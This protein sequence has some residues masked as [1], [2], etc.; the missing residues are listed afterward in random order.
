M[1]EPTPSWRRRLRST[2]DSTVRVWRHR[3]FRGARIS[4]AVGLV[5]ITAAMIGVMLFAHTGINVG[6]FRAE[7]SLS[8]S[9]A[10]GTEVDIPPLGSLHLDSHR[11]ALHLKVALGS[12][13]Q[14]RTEALIDNPAAISSAGDRAVEEVTTGV[15]RLALRAIGL[16]VLGAIL[17]A[18]LIF[19]SVRRTAAAGVTALVVGAGSFGVAA[20]TL[21]PDA[22]SEPRYEGLLVNAPAVV[23]D[24]RRIADNY[25]RY[26]EQ[27]QQIVSNVSRIYTT[28]SALP[29]YEPAGN[30]TRILHV[31]DLHLNPSS[32]GL[33]R[34]VVQTFDIDAVIDTGDM[35]DWGSSA[36]TSYVSS[37]PSLNVPYLYVR[38]NHDSVAI[39]S[40]V[41]RQRNAVVLDDKLTTVDG[42]TVAGI[43][44]PQFTPDKSETNKAGDTSGSEILTAAGDRLAKTIRDSGKKVDIALIH[45]PEMAPPLAGVVPLVLAGHRHQ[46]S[47]AMLPAWKP[48]APDPSASAAPSPTPSVSAAAA[49]P[50]IATRL[51]VEGSTGGAGLRGL[52]GEEPTPLSLSVLYFDENHNLKAYDDIRLG[53]TGESNVEMQRN[54]VGLDKEQPAVTPATSVPSGAGRSPAVTPSR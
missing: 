24:A 9:L 34:T 12:L 38:G 6:P 2:A 46:R 41:A 49:P 16:A 32:W 1:S 30:T 27:L 42:L 22:I 35:V 13:D 21:R 39:Q 3:W 17:A 23:G 29:V 37:I 40:A 33:I 20:A 25:G 19:R 47:V 10:G 53:G 50:P 45:D 54:V 51:M 43:G 28:V 7:M 36:E 5:S 15:T 44:D 31:S 14:S 26:A 8:P 4:A 18:A 11:G 52:E 48:P